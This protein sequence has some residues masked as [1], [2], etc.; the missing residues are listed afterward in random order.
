MPRP[1][2]LDSH[3]ELA[4]IVENAYHERLVSFLAESKENKKKKI[5]TNH[6][7]PN[8]ETFIIRCIQGAQKIDLSKSTAMESIKKFELCIKTLIENCKN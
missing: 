2:E 8:G 3:E 1:V 4:F 5:D 7:G 6:R